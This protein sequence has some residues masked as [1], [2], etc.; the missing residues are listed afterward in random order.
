MAELQELCEK[1][2]ERLKKIERA[3]M[4]ELVAFLDESDYFTAPASARFHN[5]FEG[6][7]VDHS[8]KVYNILAQK[9]RIYSR[10]L[11]DDTLAIVGLLHDFCKIGMYERITKRKLDNRTRQWL[12]VEGYGYRED[13]DQLGHGE[14]SVICLQRFIRL[15]DLEI[16]MIRWHMLFYEPKELYPD[17]NRAILKYPDIVLIAAADLESANLCEQVMA[18]TEAPAR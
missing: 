2:R 9:N 14:K 12:S 10:G 6:G 5:N 3:G 15:T 8:W 1:V 7:L 4:D 11:D 18:E 16:H 13:V 17:L